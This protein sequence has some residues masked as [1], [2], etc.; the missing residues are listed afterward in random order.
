MAVEVLKYK[1]FAPYIIELSKYFKNVFTDFTIATGTSA[2]TS[3]VYYGTP[4]S[5]YRR[6]FNQ[7]NNKMDLPV[8]NFY[9]VDSIRKMEKEHPTFFFNENVDNRNYDSIYSTKAPAHYEC[10]YQF[11][12]WNNSNR[13]RDVMMHKIITGF[14]QGRLSLTHAP[15]GESTTDNFLFMPMKLESNFSDDTE[16]EAV[17]MQEV[18][19]QIRTTFTIISEAIIPYDL[20]EYSII[21]G[22]IQ[23]I[24]TMINEVTGQPEFSETYSFIVPPFLRDTMV[25]TD[26]VTATVG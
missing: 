13:E 8:I 1:L 2:I 9:M 23:A 25:I 14:P 3:Q 11:Y 22:T 4:R 5:A 19:D 16:I 20:L 12:M 6:Y 17:D 15:T 10:T 24:N 26:S 18:R 7:T 21:T